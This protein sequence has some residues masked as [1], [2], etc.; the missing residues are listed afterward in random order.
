[1]AGFKIADGYVEVDVD[2]KALDK[3]IAAIEARLR[4]VKDF[5]IVLGI[6]QKLVDAA[7]L[8]I[9]GKLMALQAK[10][11]SI[12]GIN[13]GE[14]DASLAEI[15]AKLLA[16][17]EL[18]GI[19]LKVSGVD[20][21]V[22]ELT[23]VAAAVH[24]VSDA[25][26]E[27]LPLIEKGNGLFGRWNSTIQ[28]FGGTLTQIG[29][30]AMF[31]TVG[32]IHLIIDAIAEILAV[33]IPAGVALAAFGVAASSTFSDIVKSEQAMLTIT[34]GLGQSFPGLNKGLQEFT[35]SVKPEVYIL[36]GEA[37]DTIN[38]HTGLFQQLATGAGHVLDNLGA[39][40]EAALGGNGLDGFIGKGVSD[41]Q[42][43]GN[44]IGNVFGIFGNVLKSLPGYA[45]L[46]FRGLQDV[47]GALE[48]ITGS[49]IVQG[50]M[51]IGLG[52][53]GALLW[54]GLLTTALFALQAP[55]M[56]VV[57][58]LGTAANAVVKF[59]VMFSV[60]AAQEG[61]LAAASATLEGVLAAL[62]AV[63][64]FVWVAVAIGALT[65]LVVWLVNTKTAWQNQYDAIMQN[66][67]AA[68]TFTQAQLILTQGIQQTND[69]L[70]DT[71][72][73]I[74][75]TQVGMHGLTQ[76]I[77]ELNPA[78]AG[79]RQ[80]SQNL[81]QDQQTLS[82]RM[83][84]L[85]KI[86]GSQSTAL[87][88]LNVIGVKAGQVATESAADFAKQR[89]EIQALTDATTQ[90]AGFTKGPAAAAQNAL[91][92]TYLQE[93]LPAIQKI[94][95]AEDN[96]INVV[97]G[98]QLAFDT[99]GQGIATLATNF[100]QV[101]GTTLTT[102][103]NLAGLKS[104]A[105]LAGAALD[106]TSQ[107]SDA[108][109]AA[110]YTSIQ[111]AQKLND[112]VAQQSIS[113]KDLTKVVATSA[114]QMIGFAGNND[115]ARSAIVALINNALGPG[116]VTLKSL[117]QWVG[118]NQVSM[119]QYR[120]IID[121]AT[122]S[123]TQL[124]GTLNATMKQMQA[125][126]L[127]QAEGGQSAWNT[128]T[129]DVLKGDTTS[130]AFNT[131][132]QQVASQLILQAN[133][134]LPAAQRAFEQ[135]TSE[136]GLSK[137]QA[138][139]LWKA[140]LPSLQ[141]FI[142]KMHGKTLPIKADTSQAISQAQAVQQYIDA[143]HGTNLTISV[144][145]QVALAQGNMNPMKHAAGGRI[146]AGTTPTADDVPVLVSKDETIVSAAHSALLAPI[147]KAVGVP[148]YASGG[149]PHHTSTY[150]PKSEIDVL[151][152]AGLASHNANVLKAAHKIQSDKGIT[153]ERDDAR[154]LYKLLY[155]KTYNYA[156]VP[157]TATTGHSTAHHTTTHHTTTHHTTSG[158]GS[159]TSTF[160][161]V[162]EINKLLAAGLASH[163]ANVLKEAHQVQADKGHLTTERAD[164]RSLY[165][166][167]YGKTYSYANVP[168]TGTISTGHGTTSH[169]NLSAASIQHLLS[170]GLGS[171][172]AAAHNAALSLEHASSANRQAAAANLQKVLHQ[173][174]VEHKA[175]L[176]H[177]AYIKA[178][179]GGHHSSGGFLPSGAWGYVG[180]TGMEAVTSLP[181]GG[182]QITPLSNGG[183]DLGTRL[184]TLIALTRKL[185]DTTAA[186][187]SGV[188]RNVGN[189]MMTGG[190]R[191]SVQVRYGR[192]GA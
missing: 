5:S 180:E 120:G 90:L 142:D 106:G 34:T 172:V 12:G 121:K 25:E 163:N 49:S 148:G 103:H 76:R 66:V 15:R 115:A 1:M 167:L 157:H 133:G 132:L 192:G 169:H 187:P 3:S 4:S 162:S 27:V 40:A 64:P 67:N 181:G 98:G 125:I 38:Q 45:E 102:T 105:S 119:S 75:V 189:V 89:L 16:L 69:Q 93:T 137:A 30:P 153:A 55:I 109:N 74:T 94:T 61:I 20:T 165:K 53:H 123:A 41:L 60:V 85:V 39:R 174:H 155:G 160:M 164:A 59:G 84:Q 168:H 149:V 6:D 81:S 130:K 37:L 19:D 58:W 139:T 87:N 146:T 51:N 78:Y 35:D 79:L 152:A 116:T 150:V 177:Q 117:D 96:L 70:K 62:A 185:I 21:A 128:F 86:T 28:L 122:A 48:N 8:E 161:P 10:A 118:T 23:A 42:L 173:L 88:D 17:Q 33:L 170:S 191:S 158:G 99:F 65:A 141:N 7:L 14:L 127:F 9:S 131:S 144:T 2:Y 134:S 91:T 111:N 176:A 186:V 110:F 126:A 182:T 112:A 63:N 140:T 136:L 108:L 57:T 22:A 31:A 171:H 107:A 156:N 29:V 13:Q 184:D 95:Q 113:Q 190:A 97:T 54:G 92:N 83:D 143:M 104:T 52:L 151:L 100:H 73:Y 166:L 11:L 56:S 36:F 175:H 18:T 46:L 26:R 154:S 82:S 145:Q 43:L 135:Y 188:G 159:H 101:T 72:K 77:T 71:P 50:L 114:G 124:T 183:G 80:N 47:T 178:H 44:I 129:S 68:T 138:D 24:G 147:F 32:T 179:S